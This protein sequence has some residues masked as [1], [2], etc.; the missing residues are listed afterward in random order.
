MHADLLLI[1]ARPSDACRGADRG[2]DT[3]RGRADGHF[4][5]SREGPHRRRRRPRARAARRL[6]ALPR[7]EPARPRHPHRAR[8]RRRRGAARRRALA[9]RAARPARRARRHRHGLGRPD[10]R[11]A[12]QLRG[13]LPAGRL[14]PAAR[15]SQV[16][17]EEQIDVVLLYPTIGIA[18]EGLVRRS[19]PR[20][21][22]LPRL[23]PLARRLLQHRSPAAR[24]DRAHLAARPGGR[25][26]G[27]GAGAARRLR[28]R[29][30]LAGSGVARRPAVRRPEARAVLEHGAGPRDAGRVPRRRA[31]RAAARALVRRRTT[32][33]SAPWSSRSPSSRST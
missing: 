7:A 33:R 4:G 28:R 10:D 22:L 12:A 20:D 25:R 6:A 21:R 24:A 18:W 15:A 8:R 5:R 17:D 29:L 31:E 19:A 3:A 9:P 32:G 27:G 16:M 1:V 23:Q 2:T 13:R 14:R 11:R 26:R 30:S